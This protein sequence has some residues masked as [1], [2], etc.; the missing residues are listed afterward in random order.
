M[1]SAGSHDLNSRVRIRKTPNRNYEPQVDKVAK[2]LTYVFP[3]THKTALHVLQLFEHMLQDAGCSVLRT[4]KLAKS[5]AMRSFPIS[6][7]IGQTK[8]DEIILKV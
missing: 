1:E 8:E 5:P 3:E 4:L 2:A 7:R 6:P